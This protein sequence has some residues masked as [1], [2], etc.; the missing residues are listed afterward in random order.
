MASRRS[1]T[2][3][4]EGQFSSSPVL[5]LR[6]LASSSH[7]FQGQIH[8]LWGLDS[9]SGVPTA[10][11]P[12]HPLQPQIGAGTSC[13]CPSKDVTDIPW[14]P[15]V[16]SEFCTQSGRPEGHCYMVQ[17]H[18][19]PIFLK[20]PERNLLVQHTCLH[21]LAM[22]PYSNAPML[23]TQGVGVNERNGGGPGTPLKK[24]AGAEKSAS[25]RPAC[26]SRASC[27]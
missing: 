7:C 9:L 11:F 27:L 1:L 26:Q 16:H 24:K 25:S 6:F 3:Q 22:P 17:S 15:F 5:L 20:L 18:S 13:L 10:P 14:L 2:I 21:P 23:I 8:W 4:G 12:C 19:P